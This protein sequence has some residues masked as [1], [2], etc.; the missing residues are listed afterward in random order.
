MNKSRRAELKKALSFL[1]QARDII[2]YC[3]DEEQDA[4]WNLPESLQESERG[5]SM[6]E[7]IDSMDE[8]VSSIDDC[9]AS[10]DEVIEG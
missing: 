4:Y 7:C 2:E 1:G 5:E 10:L 8:A 3:R 6:S 9:V